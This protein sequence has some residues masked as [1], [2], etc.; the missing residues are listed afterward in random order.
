MCFCRV[1][2]YTLAQFN[3]DTTEDKISDMVAKGLIPS[4]RND[5]RKDM[6]RAGKYARNYFSHRVDTLPASSDAVTCLGDCIKLL[7]ICRTHTTSPT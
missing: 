2:E 4:D 3:G 7:G 1:I 6:I 5:V